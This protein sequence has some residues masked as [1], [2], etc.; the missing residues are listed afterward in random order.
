M[1][2]QDYI[3]REVFAFYGRAMYMAQAVEKGIMNLIVI[4]N[5]KHGI[6]KTR[7][8]EIL[9]EKS[10]MTFGQLKREI[11]ELNLFTEDELP[12]IEEFHKK[13]I[14][15]HILFGGIEQ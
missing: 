8:D 9:H 6:T 3:V 5:H 13:E 10:L 7:Y 14:S 15:W 2:E 11:E 4:S 12:S 1:T